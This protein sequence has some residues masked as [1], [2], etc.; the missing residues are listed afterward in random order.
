RDLAPQLRELAPAE[1]A[2]GIGLGPSLRHLACRRDPRGAQ[3][4]LQLGQRVVA[5]LVVADDSDCDCALGGARV[6][7]AGG[8]VLHCSDVRRR[9][10]PG[11]ARRPP[12]RS[13]A[14]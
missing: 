1:V 13:V 3:E 8:A 11:W 4:L 12:E 9:M 7:D 6:D 14:R 10:W 5:L 2:V